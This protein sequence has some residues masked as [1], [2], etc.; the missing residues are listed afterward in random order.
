MPRV[1]GVQRAR[2]AGVTPRV[3]PVERARSRQPLGRSA[4]AGGVLVVAVAFAAYLATA[5]RDLVF[6]DT[7]ELIA[8]ALTLGVAHAPGYPVWTLLA[9]L[10]AA[11]PLGPVP[12]RVGL[13][14]VVCG[15]ACVGV[16]YAIGSRLTRSVVAGAVAAIVLAF[17]PV[18]W[19]W[20]IV[21]EVFALN[22]LLA[23]AFMYC[24]L[25]WAEAPAAWRWL[26]GGAFA[27]GLG[28][29]NQQTIV[30]LAP[31][32]AYLLYRHGRAFAID[33]SLLWKAVAAFGLGLL[34]YLYLPIAAATDPA[35]SF[36]DIASAGDV[37]GQIGRVA[38]GS[39]QLITAPGLQG[40]Q[41]MDRLAAFGSSFTVIEAALTTLGLVRIWRRRETFWF[42]ALAL[43]FG[44]PLFAAYANADVNIVLVRSVLERFFLL[45]HVVAAPL[46]ALGVLLIVERSED[47]RAG[48]R[49]TALAIAVVALALV[50][51]GVA[52]SWTAVDR[53]A[54]RAARDFGTDLLASAPQGAL[55]IVAGDAAA[56]PVQYLRT[57]EGA[58][59]DV[60]VVQKTYLPAD[61][62]VRQL[63]RRDPSVA[64]P[65][66]S[67]DTVAANFRAF[68]AANVKRPTLTAGEL[69]DDSTQGAFV[70]EPRGLLQLVVPI[71]ATLDPDASAR[72]TDRLF[73]LY[74]PPDPAAVKGRPFEAAV[75]NDYGLALVRVGREYEAA[76]R[77]A[78]AKPW[79]ERALKVVPDLPEA[80]SGLAR[81]K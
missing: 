68:L 59:P 7:P 26:A 50:G 10:F 57:I 17:V 15:A 42:F 39:S 9:H 12:F 64:L 55:L 56:F 44:G 21:A 29:A 63:R 14:S 79:Y 76:K 18:F 66:A 3:T 22:A 58:R 30:L 11:L 19:S 31:A 8:V 47:L 35:W 81:L 13:L 80:K 4:I 54:D 73:G 52:T 67:F 16:V 34:P 24:A 48:R 69:F 46:V 20:S 71:T 2:P 1:Q 45:P 70:G 61:W 78:D 49:A 62:Y 36:G 43:L 25:R 6:G 41:P 60:S 37:I 33:P 40:G 65:F 53:H 77:P 5:A 27:F 75:L 28:L 51:V 23:A 32:A 38:Y 72:E 74:H